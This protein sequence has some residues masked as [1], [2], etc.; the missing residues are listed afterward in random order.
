M[1][2]RGVSLCKYTVTIREASHDGRN[3]EEDVNLI[4]VIRRATSVAPDSPS[5]ISHSRYI[6]DRGLPM[7]RFP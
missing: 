4:V 6:L 3:K 7:G 1:C 2:A 5:P